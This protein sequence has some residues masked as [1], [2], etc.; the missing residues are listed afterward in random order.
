MERRTECVHMLKRAA[1]F[2]ADKSAKG[3]MECASGSD[4]S[5][6]TTA[7]DMPSESVLHGC[8]MAKFDPFLCAPTPSTQGQSQERKV[9]KFAAY[10]SGAIIP[11]G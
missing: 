2:M 1:I 7:T 9:S 3:E 5:G 6:V 10:P 8:Q 4:R 11:K